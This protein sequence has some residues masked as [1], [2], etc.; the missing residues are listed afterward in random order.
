MG[1]KQNSSPEMDDGLKQAMGTIDYRVICMQTVQRPIKSGGEWISMLNLK[2]ALM[3]IPAIKGSELPYPMKMG[4]A[5]VGMHCF[6]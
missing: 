6:P 2:N 3:A 1:I 4:G 5:A